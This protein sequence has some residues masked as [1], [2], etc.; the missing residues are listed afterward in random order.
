MKNK[1]LFAIGIIS[2]AFLASSCMI[3]INRKVFPKH[4]IKGSDVY[5]SKSVN[6]DDFFSLVVED[7]GMD[8]RFEQGDSNSVEIYGP[9]N[10][11]E[12]IVVGNYNGQLTI[13]LCDSVY[14]HS[15]D[16]LCVKISGKRL[17]RVYVYGSGD[18]LLSDID[19]AQDTMT[20]SVAGS[21]DLRFAGVRAVDCSVSVC[22]SGGISIESLECGKLS[23]SISGSGEIM[24]SG[25]KAD[26]VGVS[27]AGSGDVTLSGETRVAEYGI[28]GSGDI[29]ASSLDA[30]EVSKS[31]AGSGDI[32]YKQG[33]RQFK[34]N[35]ISN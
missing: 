1:I 6:V 30:V 26:K 24:I 9:D 32:K 29:D 8:V 18:V 5:I 3:R 7:G 16:S 31:V 27:I 20:V 34:K 35:N 33:G 23:T 15:Y 2:L 11:I 19:A 28:A 25:I 21:G 14:C 12:Y 4:K 10:I 22:G 13:G 17:N